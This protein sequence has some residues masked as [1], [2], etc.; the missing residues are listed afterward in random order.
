MKN[1]P[2]LMTNTK[3]Q[4]LEAQRAPL[5]IKTTQQQQC[6][7]QLGI[8]YSNCKKPKAERVLKEA[9]GVIPPVEEQWCE[10]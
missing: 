7:T 10:V 9:R 5:R 1:F 6:N 3:P 4:I 8:L 2:K